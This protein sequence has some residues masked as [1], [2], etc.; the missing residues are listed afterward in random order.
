MLNNL[1]YI[2]KGGLNMFCKNCG[3]EVNLGSAVCPSCGTQMIVDE[4]PF[5]AKIGSCCFPIV[6]LVLYIVWKQDKPASAKS[7]GSIPKIV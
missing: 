7:V 5:I 1:S 2:L 3:N 4:A 6:G